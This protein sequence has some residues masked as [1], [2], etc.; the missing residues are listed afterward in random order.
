NDS[1]GYAE[2]DAVIARVLVVGRAGGDFAPDIPVVVAADAEH[3][4][5]TAATGN[6]DIT[7]LLT[8]NPGKIRQDEAAVVR[9]HQNGGDA[10]TTREAAPPAEPG[11]PPDRVLQRAVQ[12]HRGLS[13]PRTGGN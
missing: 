9:R 5:W 2:A 1:F 7:R 10:R 11:L 6:E 4:A 8:D 12:L 3:A 13:V